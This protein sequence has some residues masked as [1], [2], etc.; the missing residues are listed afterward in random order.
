MSI[1]LKLYNMLT[2]A[3]ETFR[4]VDPEAVRMYVCGP[5]VYDFAHIG[6]G[7][8]AIVFDLLFRLL[9]H[10]YSEAN[11]IYAR[12]VTDVD[13]KII[14]RAQLDFP[15]LPLNEAIAHVTE[16]TLRQ[17][18]ADVAASLLDRSEEV[19]RR[20]ARQVERV[21]AWTAETHLTGW[22]ENRSTPGAPIDDALTVAEL[23][24]RSVTVSLI[25][26]T[27]ERTNLGR[28]EPGR[29][30]NLEVDVLAKYVERL[31]APR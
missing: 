23:G 7:R 11:V 4:P 2:G 29:P 20:A 21:H 9:R 12:N 15:D 19:V 18:R 16:G 3:K 14:A 30:V 5:T 10:A 22:A 1:V 6:N 31:V 27:L 24:D 28:A 25:P 26:E 17:Y 13:D 8:A